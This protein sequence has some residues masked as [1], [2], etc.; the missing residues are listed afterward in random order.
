MAVGIETPQDGWEEII[1]GHAERADFV[2]QEYV[3]VP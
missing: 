2:V 1:A 3:P